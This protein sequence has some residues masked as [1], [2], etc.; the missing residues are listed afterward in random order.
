MFQD[1]LEWWFI[2]GYFN[3][4]KQ[5]L[6]HFMMA[7][8][9]HD[10]SHMG[11]EQN[12]FSYLLSVLD[13]KSKI[14][15]SK[16]SVEKSL[17]DFVIQNRSE[18]QEL[19]LDSRLIKIFLDEI[20]NHSPLREIE[21]MKTPVNFQKQLLRIVGDEFSFKQ[22]NNHFELNFLEPHTNLNCRMQLY[23]TRKGIKL[24]TA[25]HI[26]GPNLGM[27]YHVYPRLF[28]R[29]HRGSVKIKGEAW[30]DHQW[31]DYDWLIRK[32]TKKRVLGWDWFGFTL[33][34]GSDWVVMIHRDAQTRESLSQYIVRRD[35][36][37][38][39][40]ECQDFTV[41][42]LK[43]WRSQKTKIQHPIEWHIMASKFG[44]DLTFVPTIENQELPVFGLMR[45]IWEGAGKVEG[46][47]NGI[48]VEGIARGEFQGYGYI[49]NFSDFLESYAE[50][51]D[52][53][54][55]EFLPK[56][57]D[58]RSVEKY[59]GPP[60]WLNEPSAF[61]HMLSKPFWDL[62][63]R[64]GKRWRPIFGLILLD[65]LNKETE[66][67]EELVSAIAELSHTGSLII[68]DIEDSSLLRRGDECI[69][70]R[71]GQDVAIN[72]ANTLYFLPIILIFNHPLLSKG[73]KLEI[74]EVLM[75]KF[76]RAHF[77]QTLDLYWSRHMTPNRLNDWLKNSMGQ[78]ILQMYEY[79]TAAPVEGLGECAAIIAG[80]KKAT[81]EL[82][83]EFARNLGIAFQIIDDINNFSQSQ[84]WR[85]IP[86]ED[87][88]EGKL[89][90]VV[91][92][93]L[94][95]LNGK[96]REKLLKIIS[97]EELRKDP[98]HY[99]EGCRLVRESGAREICRREAEELVTPS[100]IK[101]SQILQPS[102]PKIQL[103]ALYLSLL[104]PLREY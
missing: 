52:L 18:F 35:E 8:F 78:K 48:P 50:R 102:E 37:G 38:K 27:K 16:S 32:G 30:L 14:Q 60:T 85:K 79:K 3:G 34:D 80:A 74:H 87:I 53:R 96:D 45:A 98:S 86:G 54:L 56:E 55:K 95:N 94:E 57:F 47:V 5:N 23:P 61:S 66:P 22:F 99:N 7:L 101:L 46:T 63:L 69:H 91:Y 73:Q 67:Y 82:C 36:K 31:G 71:Y 84:D 10:I 64:K 20:Q 6:K 75:K 19:N 77:G 2:H 49:F 15:H 65:A 26:S 72:A 4:E 68:D 83:A 100:W 42:V 13:T 89:T 39:I 76:I 43:Y 41:K 62:V 40:E 70:I 28:L 51:V 44:V 88:S 81:R 11:S 17:L 21:L 97:S 58:E 93:A 33:N 104:D 59:V 1:S 24:D 103:C 92:R 12:S 90:Y 29:G 25:S 9:R